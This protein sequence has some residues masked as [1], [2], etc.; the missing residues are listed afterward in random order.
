MNKSVKCALLA[1]PLISALLYSVHPSSGQGKGTVQL[2]TATQPKSDKKI[3]Q[4]HGQARVNSPDI[5]VL[6]G[7]DG[8]QSTAS[9]IVTTGTTVKRSMCWTIKFMMMSWAGSTR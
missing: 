7:D 8:K 5:A 9:S 6:P 2:E 3:V 4:P 1:L